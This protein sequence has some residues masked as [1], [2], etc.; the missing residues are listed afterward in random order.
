[1]ISGVKHQKTFHFLRQK[2]FNNGI[3]F[4]FLFTNVSKRPFSKYFSLLV[5]STIYLKLKARAR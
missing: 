5:E 1:M 2:Q 3:K 4:S